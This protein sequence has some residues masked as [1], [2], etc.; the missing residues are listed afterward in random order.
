MV[1]TLRVI[2]DMRRE[3]SDM[4][5][6]LLALREQQRRAR[7]P[8]PKARIPDHQDASGDADS[9][10]QQIMAPTTRRGPNTLVNN[11]NP[12]NLTPESI[13]A[14]IDQALLRNST[15]GD[16][17][18]SSHEDNQRNVQTAHPCFYADFMMCQPLN[19]KGTEGV[20][21]LTRWIEKMELVFNISGCAIENQ[22]NFST[23]TPLGA[24]LTWW[25]GQIRT[26]G[27]EA[28]AMTWEILKKKMTDKYCPQG[29]IKKLEIELWNIKVKE[30]DVP[31]YTERF[32]ELTLICTKFVSNETEK[33]DKYISGLPNNIYGNVRPKTLDETI[34]LANELM[35]Q[36]LCTYTERQ[37][38]NKR[39]ADDLS[40]NNH[41]EKK[42]YEGSLPKCTKCHLHHNGP[43]TQKCYKCNKVGHFARD[44]KGTG[45]INVDNTQKG[46][47]AA[48]KGNGCFECGA[49]G[50]FKRDCPKLKNKDG[51]NGNTQG[52]VYAFMNA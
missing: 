25:N 14:M 2:R 49:P 23:Y 3:M 34:E 52:W 5:A 18:H 4:Q 36:K 15:I 11:T 44:C 42:P 35:D 20:V 51:G 28:Y 30:N 43:C 1:E 24:A 38:D 13:Q 21:G 19:F 39:K 16:G 17:S 37:S 6:E 40:R 10:I 26:L 27:H 45:N 7:Q 29:E 8:G 41:G 33:V 47:G 31:A 50:H 9:H 48:P 46:N 12:N 22:V 32:Q